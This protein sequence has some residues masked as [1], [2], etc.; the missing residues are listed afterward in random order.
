MVLGESRLGCFGAT[1]KKFGKSFRLLLGVLFAVLLGT[2]SC[3]PGLTTG[4][5]VCCSTTAVAAMSPQMWG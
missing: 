3:P 4:A 5:N 1:A 2:M